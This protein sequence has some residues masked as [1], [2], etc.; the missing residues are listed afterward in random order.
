METGMTNREWVKRH[1]PEAIND[2]A[3]GGVVGCPN[4]SKYKLE[5]HICKDLLWKSDS[6]CNKCWDLPAKRNGK[7]II[8]YGGAANE[9]KSND[10]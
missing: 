8:L 1:Y 10:K 5:N 2:L 3:Y 6:K 4:D 9:N 7:E